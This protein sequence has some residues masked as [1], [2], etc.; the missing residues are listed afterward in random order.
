[1]LTLGLPALGFSLGAAVAY[2]I[3]DYF[4]KAVPA[5]CPVPL[6][7]FYAFALETPVVAVWLWI[8]G[9]ARLTPGYALPGLAAVAIGLAANALFILAVRRSPLSMMIPMMG[10]MPVLTALVSGLLLG[11]WPGERQAAGIVLVAAGLFIVYIPQGR[12][13]AFSLAAVWHNFRQEPGTKPM[14][15]VVVLW[16]IGP[17][18]DKLC[19]AEASVGMHALVQLV[20][21]WAVVGTWLLARG[22]LSNLVL[23]RSALK[24]LLGVS[25]MAGIGYGMQLTAYRM[26][27]VAVV[28]VFKRSLGMAGAL[29]LG[30]VFFGESITRTKVVG[31]AIIAAGLPLV[32]LG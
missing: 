5:N 21:L 3:A 11:E 12:E 30:R 16:S 19:L 32:L 25:L 6:M 10:L 14:M 20:A 31:V 1:M 7:L 9:D 26:T 22:G 13:R 24:P 27:L 29:V 23:P 28:E 8:S 2:S 15:G 18:V 4:R 17:P